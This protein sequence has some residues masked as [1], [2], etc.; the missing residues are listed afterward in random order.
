VG[1]IVF[2]NSCYA[3]IHIKPCMFLHSVT[4]IFY[5]IIVFKFEMNNQR[6]TSLK[7]IQF[8]AGLYFPLFT[9]S[10]LLSNFP[11]AAVI[12]AQHTS[13]ACSVSSNSIYNQLPIVI[14]H[15]QQSP[16]CGNVILAVQQ[17]FITYHKALSAWRMI[18]NFQK[19][20]CANTFNVYT[21]L[22]LNSFIV[23]IN[24]QHRKN[25]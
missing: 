2:F 1:H 23:H 25:L 10:V 22:G 12:I 13:L 20:R 18:K 4:G 17:A 21:V 6:S 11:T 16:N 14:H 7:S 8:A 19:P 24:L 9:L 15:Y 5:F 3:N